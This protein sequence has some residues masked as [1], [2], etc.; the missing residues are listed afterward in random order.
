MSL[1]YSESCG[2]TH[3]AISQRVFTQSSLLPN[4]LALHTN[5]TVKRIGGGGGLKRK[6]YV[7]TSH[8]GDY[9]DGDTAPGIFN[10]GTITT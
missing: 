8:K 9:A 7:Y 10:P 5:H 6:L 4:S 3:N 2:R 1:F